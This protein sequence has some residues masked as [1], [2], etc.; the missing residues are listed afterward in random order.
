MEAAQFEQ[1]RLPEEI[2]A[3]PLQ[4]QSPDQQA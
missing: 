1:K 4:R 2:K 3:D